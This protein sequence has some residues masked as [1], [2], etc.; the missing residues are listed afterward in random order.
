MISTAGL[1]VAKIKRNVEA[2]WMQDPKMNG[3]V[4]VISATRAASLGARL[5]QVIA[6]GGCV[7]SA[8]FV[9][10][11]PLATI[12]KILGLKAGELSGG[13]ALLRLNRFPIPKEFDLA[14]YTNVAAYPGYPPGLGSNQWVVKA[15]IPATVEKLVGPGGTF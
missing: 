15:D 12:E 13:G 3:P 9:L 14:G 11:K 2:Y 1:D 10:G 8:K 6:V 5:G 4:K 7:V